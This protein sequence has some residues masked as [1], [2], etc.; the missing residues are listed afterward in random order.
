MRL[1]CKCLLAVT[2]IGIVF[3]ISGSVLSRQR[4]PY[5][6]SV[7]VDLVLLNVRA[8]YRNGEVVTGLP[9]DNFK[10]YEDERLQELAVFIGQ[11]APATIGLVVDSSASMARKWTEVQRAVAT[12]AEESNP[13]DEMFIIQFSDEIHWA[14]PQ[15]KAFTTDAE[16]IQEAMM[17]VSPSG[18]TA[19]YDAIAGGLDHLKKG[20]FEKKILVIL[21][22][23]ADN[24]SVQD[25]EQ[26]LAAARQASV[27]L[28]TIGF[29]EPEAEDRN[30]KVLKRLAAVTGGEAYFPRSEEE[31]QATWRRIADGVR[32]QYTLGYYP[33]KPGDGTFRKVKVVV[34]SPG[35]AKLSVHTRPGYLARMRRNDTGK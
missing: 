30:P 6:V 29:Y 7:D 8:L 25:F 23:G 12:F 1:L 9:K 18:R 24:A 13:R 4:E 21:S 14:L 33:L 22:D 17:K 10:V 15:A 3:P 28:Y 27:T 2:L 19:L 11:G 34:K 26:L 16:E 31:L 32:T 5:T 20:R 35:G